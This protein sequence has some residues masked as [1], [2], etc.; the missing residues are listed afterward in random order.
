MQQLRDGKPA[1]GLG[2]YSFPVAARI[3]SDRRLE[4]PVTSRALR[5]WMQVG[6]TPATFGKGTPGSVVLSFYDLVSLEVVRK[7]REA[8]ASLQAIRALEL[9]L[10]ERAPDL[11]RPFA[12][13]IFLTDGESIWGQLTPGHVVELVGKRPEQTGFKAIVKSFA[14]EIDYRDRLAATWRLTPW[15]E[16]DPEVHFGAPVVAGTSVPVSSILRNLERQPPDVV[17]DAYGLELEQVNG[18]RGYSDAA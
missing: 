13:E 1:F 17:A 12:H 11:P 7:L 5:Y 4:R 10:R 9:L 15:V 6:L 16:V 18:V 2:I 14:Q 8:G 3:I